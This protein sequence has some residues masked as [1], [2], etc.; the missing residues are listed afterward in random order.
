MMAIMTTGQP[1]FGENHE[2]RNHH[3][4][5]GNNNTVGRVSGVCTEL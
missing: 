3:I 1:I 2:I 5:I 4:F